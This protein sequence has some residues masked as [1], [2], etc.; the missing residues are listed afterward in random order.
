MKFISE[1]YLE[2]L[3]EPT[4]KQKIAGN[5]K[6]KHVKWNG[7]DISIENQANTYRSG[8]SKDG[9][10]WKT[11]MYY[12]YGY[13]KGTKGKDKDHLDVFLGPNLDSNT[14]YIVNQINQT[15]SKFDEHK[16]MLGFDSLK[17]AREGYL[18]NYEVGWKCGDVVVM[19]VDDFKNWLKD[20]NKEL[21]NPA[22]L[23]S[24]INIFLRNN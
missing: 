13:V 4:E 12:D 5:Y 14:V 2:N 19:S 3:S 6:K 7:L 15:D 8:T 21:N 23:E 20:N 1:I 24:L 16:C 22:K 18:K 17:D 9:K 10:E 11:K